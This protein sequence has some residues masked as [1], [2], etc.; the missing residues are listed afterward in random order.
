MCLLTVKTRAIRLLLPGAV[1]VFALVVC[2]L[3][4]FALAARYALLPRRATP[5]PV[6]W[7]QVQLIVMLMLIPILRDLCGVYAGTGHA[8]HRFA[9]RGGRTAASTE[10]VVGG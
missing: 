2:A 10:T 8:V 9:L 6:H 1:S 4:A 3:G 5:I 7:R